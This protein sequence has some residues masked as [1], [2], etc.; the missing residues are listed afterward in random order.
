MRYFIT[1]HTGFKGAWFTLWLTSLGHEVY[2]LSLNPDA[3]SLFELAEVS[4]LCK[5]DQRGDIRDPELVKAAVDHAKPDVVVHMAAQPLVLDSYKRPRWTI[6]TNVMGTLNVLEAVGIQNC[7]KALLVV[8]TDKV[9]RNLNRR[10]GYNE[11][12]SLGGDDPYSASKAMADILTH[13]WAK[14]FPG[15][16]TAIVRAGNV[17]GGGDFSPDRLLPD[18]IASLRAGTVPI[19]RHPEAVR[20]WQHVLDCLNGYKTLIDKMVTDKDY[21]QFDGG[22]NFGP[23]TDSFISVGEITT[24]VMGKWG[25]SGTWITDSREKLG[26]AQLL[27]LDSS[28]ARKA[29]GWKNLLGVEETLSWTTDW[30]RSFADGTHPQTM[31]Q[32]HIKNYFA[33]Q[34]KIRTGN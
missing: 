22:W 25:A 17:I 7:V 31:S 4:K 9:Y 30:Y 12:D 26:E 28:K 3:E 13:S 21:F 16:T 34:E 18:I 14:S 29:L 24:T 19:L 5:F 27:M 32:Q 2:G 10:Q 20:P 15:T 23:D 33:L 6:E 1:G 8:T 11:S